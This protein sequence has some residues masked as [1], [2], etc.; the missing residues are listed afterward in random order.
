MTA[1][2]ATTD[3]DAAA[4]HAV[5]GVPL[6]TLANRH[7]T[8]LYVYDGDLMARRVAEIRDALSALRVRILYSAKANPA[9]AVA[10]LLRSAGTG[11]DACSPGDLHLA[12]L[13]GFGR[14]EISY[15]SHGASREELRLAS[16]RAGTLILDAIEEIPVVAELTDHVGLRVNPGIDAGFHEHV[17]AATSGAKF[18]I[19]IEQI[20]EAL[21]SAARHGVRV[22]GFHA[23]LGS[24]FVSTGPHVELLSQLAELARTTTNIKWLNIGGGWGVP[25]RSAAA[26]YDWVGFAAAAASILRDLPDV[27]LHVEPG[28]FLT[29]DSGWLLARVTGVRGATG[30]RPATITTDASTNHVVSVLMYDAHHPI[31]LAGSPRPASVHYR[32]TGNLMQAGDIIARDVELPEASEGD[33]LAVGLVG[34]YSSCRATTFNERPRPAEVLV[35]SGSD[36]LIRRAETLDELFN[37]DL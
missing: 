32:V 10:R 17:R 33:V 7:G 18:G 23:H 35:T 9:V 30:R 36:R 15:T 26:R 19:R 28:A 16:E 20:P 34:G 2:T 24:E 27:E 31:V 29:I 1:A 8:P 37:R 14:A 11:L 12:Q 5:G 25:R 6:D 21:A 3:A 22:T 13:A 4:T